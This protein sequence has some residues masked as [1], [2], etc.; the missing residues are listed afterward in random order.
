MKASQSVFNLNSNNPGQLKVSNSAFEILSRAESNDELSN[1]REEEEFQKVEITKVSHS[2][3]LNNNSAKLRAQTPDDYE[4]EKDHVTDTETLVS[5][6]KFNGRHAAEEF[7][8]S[9]NVSKFYLTPP[10]VCASLC[11]CVRVVSISHDIFG[12]FY[13]NWKFHSHFL[14]FRVFVL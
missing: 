3:D 5:E 8:E 13:Q 11:V 12:F 2:K 7:N 4:I 1:V 9:D 6:Q 10:G 14:I